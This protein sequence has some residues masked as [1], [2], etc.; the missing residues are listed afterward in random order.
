MQ[1][2]MGLSWI[3]ETQNIRENWLGSMRK[4]LYVESCDTPIDP[5]LGSV[6]TWI[7][8]N[9]TCTMDYCL[10]E[11]DDRFYAKVMRKDTNCSLQ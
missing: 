3:P 6:S 1:A 10:C 4:Q 11:M 7:S 9:I 5:G 2:S 8:S